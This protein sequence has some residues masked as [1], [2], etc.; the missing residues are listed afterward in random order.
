[1]CGG[2]DGGAGVFVG[3]EGGTVVCG[4]CEGGTGVCVVALPLPLPL[5]IPTAV[6]PLP[7]PL[8]IL[9][10][11]VGAAAD[12]FA[13]TAAAEPTPPVPVAA[14]DPCVPSGAVTVG[15][16][17]SLLL[18]PYWPQLLQVIDVPVLPYF[19]CILFSSGSLILTILGLPGFT[20]K[21]GGMMVSHCIFGHIFSPLIGDIDCPYVTRYAAL[22]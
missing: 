2:W 6:L 19:V 22:L 11:A 20:L 16:G 15:F 21:I 3:C 8:T 14:S 1:M 17:H 10:L 4:G 12:P 7:L 18:C 9:D 5:V 13:S